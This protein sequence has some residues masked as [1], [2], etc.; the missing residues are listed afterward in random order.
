MF[1]LHYNIIVTG[2]VQE[3]WFRKYTFDKA[4]ELGLC[5]FVK[6]RPNNDVYIEVE[7]KSIIL[8][9][10][11]SWLYTGSPQSKVEK[12]IYEVDKLEHFKRFTIED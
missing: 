3:V 4:N 1:H 8:N 11:I 6:N 12:V 5:G 2:K 9:N 7:G 10:F